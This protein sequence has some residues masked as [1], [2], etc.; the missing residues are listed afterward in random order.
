MII[1]NAQNYREQVKA[2]LEAEKLPTAD[3]PEN[4]G[5]FLVAIVDNKVV[6]VAGMEVYGNYGLL[7]SVAVQPDHRGLGIAGKLIGRIASLG[8]QKGLSD[9]YLLTETAPGYFKNKG[10]MQIGREEVPAE[11]QG[12]SEFSHVCPV[13][14]IVMKKSIS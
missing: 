10:F 9:L 2:L 3:L 1:D 12:S 8:S 14:A 11:I 5:N 4:P 7:R 13:S 6:G